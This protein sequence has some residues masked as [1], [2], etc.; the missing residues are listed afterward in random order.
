VP[1]PAPSPEPR[2]ATTP[3]GQRVFRRRRSA[4]PAASTTSWPMTNDQAVST[5]DHERTLFRVV[6]D[7]A[8]ARRHGAA[9]RVK[10]ADEHELHSVLI[11]LCRWPVAS[12][13]VPLPRAVVSG[14][15]ADGCCP[16]QTP[17]VSEIEVS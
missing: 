4:S 6:E 3:D 9:R 11:R 7:S 13:A 16:G 5:V 10:A 14:C 8:D 15:V 1:S 12:L 2:R 17:G